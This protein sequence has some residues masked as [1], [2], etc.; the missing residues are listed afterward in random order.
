LIL[1]FL[2]V[3]LALLFPSTGLAAPLVLTASMEHAS[4]EG[5]LEHFA[6]TTNKL[7]FKDIRRQAFISIPEFRSQGY[8]TSSHWYTELMP[9]FCFFIIR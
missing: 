6:D 1:L 2:A 3:V 8:D 7:S 9:I 4:L 5:A